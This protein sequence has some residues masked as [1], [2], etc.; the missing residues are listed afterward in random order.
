[1]GLIKDRDTVM[2]RPVLKNIC[3][4]NWLFFIIVTFLFMV[5]LLSACG[6]KGVL[7][8]PEKGSNKALNTNLQIINLKNTYT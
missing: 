5:S 3:W 7:I 1:V 2:K 6:T 4:G 8:L